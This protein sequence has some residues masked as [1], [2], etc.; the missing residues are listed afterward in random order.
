MTRITL[1]SLLLLLVG[2]CRS[3]D[4]EQRDDRTVGRQ[5]V[6]AHVK[7]PSDKEIVLT[8]TFSAPRERVFA[9]LT[10][11]DEIAQWMESTGMEL[12]T[13]EVDLRVGGAL[14]YV[15]KRPNGRKLE[16]RGVF[17]A[18]DSPQSITYLES[19]DFSPLQVLVTTSLRSTGKTTQFT[20]TLLYSTKAERDED[21]DGVVT[22]SAEAH[23]ELERYL[24]K[25]KR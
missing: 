23:E 17:R 9:A 22:S 6:T 24:K 18:V 3:D 12:V 20:Q 19:Y 7:T 8:R 10:Q 25:P 2:S 11:P 14:R 4:D 13:A 16:V 1:L 5:E 21:Y 15:F